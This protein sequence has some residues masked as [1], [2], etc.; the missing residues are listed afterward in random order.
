[1]YTVA[2][3]EREPKQSALLKHNFPVKVSLAYRVGVTMRD[4]N[5]VKVGA[6]VPGLELLPIATL[7][8][9]MSQVIRTHSE[10]VHS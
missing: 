7:N 9:L 5:K 3:K 6:A 2:P 4:P 8:R 1:M 10:A